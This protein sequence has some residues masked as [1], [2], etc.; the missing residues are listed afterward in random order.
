LENLGNRTSRPYQDWKPL[1]IK[2]LADMGIEYS[3]VRWSQKAGCSMCPCSPGFV[4]DDARYTDGRRV[5]GLDIWLTL[6]AEGAVKTTD[7]ELAADRMAQVAADPTIPTEALVN[8]VLTPART[9]T[10]A[11]FATS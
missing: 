11:D 3:R 1:V 6:A 8:T 2:Q 9:F 7:P 5:T 4:V 10:F